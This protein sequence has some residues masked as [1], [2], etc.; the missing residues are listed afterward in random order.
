MTRS[1]G[2]R[3]IAFQSMRWPIRPGPR[4]VTVRDDVEELVVK[5]D[6]SAGFHSFGSGSPCD[7]AHCRLRSSIVTPPAEPDTQRIPVRYWIWLLGAAVSLLGDLTMTFAH[8][9]VRQPVRRPDR[10]ARPAGGRGPAGRAA[11]DRWCRRRP[12]RRT[13]RAAASCVVDVRAH[14]GAGARH[15]ALRANRSGCCSLTAL[16][17]GVIDAFFLPSSRS[18]PRLLVPTGA[19]A[20]RAGQLP[21]HRRGLRRQRYGGRR[22]SWS[23]G[24]D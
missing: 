3:M 9:L 1:C 6:G 23:A 15:D 10:R 8:R 4:A 5:S 11:A 7:P 14:A 12:L 22:A 20:A 17:V 18:M 24:P 2:E 13:Q 16:A 21:G 19:S